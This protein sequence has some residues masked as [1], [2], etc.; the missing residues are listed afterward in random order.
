MHFQPFLRAVMGSNNMHSS[1]LKFQWESLQS[2]RVNATELEA[3]H[4]IVTMTP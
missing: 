4:T 3:E 2:D 1:D